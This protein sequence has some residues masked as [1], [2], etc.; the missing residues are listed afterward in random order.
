MTTEEILRRGGVTREELGRKVHE[1]R[2]GGVF[3]LPAWDRL[4]RAD[5]EIC[6]RIGEELFCAGWEARMP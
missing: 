5:Q 2:S 4:L 1:L 6:T 3:I